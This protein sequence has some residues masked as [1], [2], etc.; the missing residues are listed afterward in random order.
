MTRAVANRATFLAAATVFASAMAVPA[1]ARQ[2]IPVSKWSV[3][4]HGGAVAAQAARGTG[5]DEFPAG[6]PF[7]T[8]GSDPSRRIPSWYFGDGARLFNQV[9]QQFDTQFGIDFA[10]IVPLD[11][12]V[13]G[14][15]VRRAT[16]VSAGGRLTRR[17]SPRYSLEIGV[18]YARTPLRLDDDAR[19]AIEETRASFEDGFTG[20]LETAPIAGLVVRS[21]MEVADRR[22]HQTSVTGSVVI[23]LTRHQQG[24]LRTHAVA[25]GGL[26]M[27]SGS[28]SEVRL[29]GG[30]QFSLFGA[31]PYNENDNVTIRFTD[32]RRSPIGVVGG[33]LTY[34]FRARQAVRIDVRAQLGTSGVR[35]VVSTAAAIARDTP[36]EVMP[37]K[38]SPSVQFSTIDGHP[39]SLMPGATDL[40]T[41]SG[42]G[43]QARVQLTVGYVFKF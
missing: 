4:I 24:R 22:G 27:S 6:V 13:T 33:G 14:G 26:L 43:F 37:S 41:F 29:R 8:A 12:T 10:R 11:S 39:S 20:L 5:I 2:V 1:A 7:T 19:A 40:E 3:E 32:R 17:L 9:Q 16:G 18:E 25:G 42:S 21:T 30:Y 23:D 38:T 28:A 15:A 34:D 31:H 36:V 35:T